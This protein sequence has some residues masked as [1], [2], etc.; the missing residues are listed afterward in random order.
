MFAA[1]GI[2]AELFARRRSSRAREVQV[3]IF[4]S[5]LALL[6]NQG[7]SWLASGEEPQRR[8]NDHPSVAPY[9]LFTAGAGE[10]VLAVGSDRQFAALADVLS[11]P[12]LAD[13]P[14]FLTNAD[15]VRNREALRMVLEEK[16]VARSAEEWHEHLQRAGVPCGRV[17]SV[18][19]ALSGP[20]ARLVARVG[21]GPGP[22]EAHVMSPIRLDGEYL[23]PYAPSPK[24]GDVERPG[25]VDG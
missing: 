15:R 18:G 14:R 9:G 13:D 3:S 16:L 19:E 11:A 1:V 23:S 8:G 24:L 21:E 20:G 10:L 4:D 17:S 12:G 2:L 7:A 22:G 6:V 5:A 25:P